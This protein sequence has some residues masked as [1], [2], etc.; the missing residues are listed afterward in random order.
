MDPGLL[1]LVT[2]SNTDGGIVSPSALAVLRLITSS[3]F[4]G[5]S[6]GSS[7]G[8]TPFRI[9]LTKTRRLPECVREVRPVGHQPPLFRKVRV[10]HRGREPAAGSSRVPALAYAEPSV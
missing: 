9:L 2:A 6:T 8:L 4:M 5:R 1:T 10:Q 7:P 3:N